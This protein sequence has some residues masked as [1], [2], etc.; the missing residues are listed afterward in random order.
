[1][2][3][4]WLTVLH[5]FSAC[6]LICVSFSL[7]LLFVT[8]MIKKKKDSQRPTVYLMYLHYSGCFAFSKANKYLNM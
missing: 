2:A 6:R 5:F 1:M 8:D 4:S 3:A 7:W